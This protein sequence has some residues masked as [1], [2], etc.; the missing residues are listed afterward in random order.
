MKDDKLTIFNYISY[1]GPA[2]ALS[3]MAMSFF[4]YGP[5]YYSDEIGLNLKLIG[6]VV[7]F[8]RIWDAITDPLCGYLT[9][10]TKS[11][12]GRRMPWMMASLIPLVFLF[13]LVFNPN[14]FHRDINISYLFTIVVILFF[15]L[16]TT[17]SIPFEA[18]GAEITFDYNERNK[19]FGIRESFVVL[20]TIGAASLP[21]VIAKEGEILKTLPN[22]SFIYSAILVISFI[23]CFLNIKE[24]PWR[25]DKIPKGSPLKN[26]KEVWGNEAFR[27][28]LTSYSIGAFSGALPATLILYYVEN[29]L[30]A[31]QSQANLFLLEY[32]IVGLL[33]LPLW[34]YL[35]KKIGKKEAWILSMLVNTLSFIGV[36]FLGKGDLTA[37]G[38]LVAFSAIGYGAT[39]ALPSSMQADVIDIDEHKY[40]TRKEGQFVGLWAIAK[41]SASAIGAGAALWILGVTGYVASGEQNEQT[42]FALKILYAA[43]PCIGN[44]IAIAIAWNYPITK[45]MHLKI[46]QEIESKALSL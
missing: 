15:L 2:F 25:A 30:S 13:I 35:A 44:I 24:K 11:R 3:I 9:D 28:L 4:V 7:F 31:S 12:F 21:L 18:L 46:R 19:L 29:V 16:W 1:A 45:D 17:F 36:F 20:G 22:L 42:I 37:Y 10:R 32:F 27:I 23:L 33:F 8:S 39:L 40:G 41:K 14:L 6:A 5:K 26:V 38:I 43:V 34:V